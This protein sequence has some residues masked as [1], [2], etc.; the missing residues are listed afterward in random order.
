MAIFVSLLFAFVACDTTTEPGGNNGGNNTNP[1]DSI[2]NEKD[3]I[4]TED[5]SVNVASADFTS[6]IIYKADPVAYIFPSFG[7]FHFQGLTNNATYNPQ[8]G[9]TIGTGLMVEITQ[10]FSYT[11]NNLPLATEFT[12]FELTADNY[13]KEI[14]SGATGGV[15]IYEIVDGVLNEENYLSTRD[16]RVTLEIGETSVTFKVECT[17]EGEDF[18][19]T[20][21]GAPMLADISGFWREAKDEGAK[22]EGAESYAVAQVIYYGETGILPVNIIEV[23]LLSQDQTSF[24]DFFCYGSLDNIENVYGT[25][26][27][28][29]EHTEGS[30]AKGPGL[31]MSEDGAIAYP[32]FIARNYSQTG[33][34]YYFVEGGS[35]TIEEN[36]ISF[37]LTSLNGSK[38]TANYSGAIEVLSYREAYPNGAPKKAIAKKSA[39]KAPLFE[40]APY[41]ILF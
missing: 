41:Y 37:D 36:K 26:N 11:E 25:F 19:F 31:Y 5:P 6:M 27:V 10:A 17:I 32:S 13:I 21:E 40:V 20:F 12:P 29:T 14:F 3:T 24:A 38:I 15:A 23:V 8:T 28:A 1:G 9:E 39:V 34:D 35:L 18:V 30:M 22:F 4:S 16:F 2:P 7:Q 33:A